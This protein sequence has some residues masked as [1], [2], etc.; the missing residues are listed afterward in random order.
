MKSSYYFMIGLIV[1]LLT[2]CSSSDNNNNGD[3]TP[4]T[5]S[6][7]AVKGIVQGAT[8]TANEL[9]SNGDVL[10]VVGTA[11]TDDDGTYSIELSDEYDGGP[12][13]IVM[14]ATSGTTNMICDVR[15]ACGQVAFGDPVPLDNNFSMSAMVGAANS[16]D[17]LTVQITPY[18]S[19]AA[20]RAKAAD[21]LTQAAV[22]AANS[23][24][25]NLLGGLDILRLEP[26]DLTDQEDID[27]ADAETQLYGAFVSAIGRMAYEG[28]DDVDA[29]IDLL[30]RSF[31][32]GTLFADDSDGDDDA[33]I[34]LQEIIDSVGDQLDDLDLDDD[35]GV[36]ASL[37]SDVNDAEGGVIDPEPSPNA[38]DSNIELAKAL[39][40]EIRT[41]G[42]ELESLESPADEFAD[43]IEMAGEVSG[44][45]LTALTNSMAGAISLMGTTLFETSQGEAGTYPYTGGVDGETGAGN[46]TISISQGTVTVTI[47]GTLNTETLDLTLAF[48]VLGQSFSEFSADFSGTISNSGL[49]A[50]ISDTEATIGFSEPVSFDV[51]TVDLVDPLTVDSLGLSGNVELTQVGETDPVSFEGGMSIE[52]ERFATTTEDDF[53]PTSFSLNGEFSN[54]NNSFSSTVSAE[55]DNTSSFNAASDVSSTNF[56]DATLT[57]VFTA[58]LADL[59]EAQLTIVVNS[60]GF[61]DTDEDLLGNVSITISHGGV[62]TR[63]VLSEESTDDTVTYTLTA[64]N[65]DGAQ[66]VLT[67]TAPTSD[68]SNVSDFS[69]TISVGST[70]VGSLSELGDGILKIS[71]NDG[72]FETVN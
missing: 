50:T 25:T 13:E 72:T 6:G 66:L 28:D 68:E 4:A 20:R 39:M 48:T 34:S 19:M 8:V 35:T 16:G 55:L 64:T 22:Q 14:S 23:E 45:A 70:Q 65:Q 63:L 32:E 43:E 59:P 2:A 1:V 21:A 5:M 62:T 3:S 7:T 44:D 10:R 71:Y 51:E 11:T 46:V 17:N 33:Q 49:S 69:G 42:T 40:T 52:G 15:P 41:W 29:A 60:T 54:T 47:E 67:G 9:A 58:D 38:G 31:E 53:I 18:T 37:Q 26:V 27:D 61:D 36:L 12:I 24:V 30:A 57:M 56:P